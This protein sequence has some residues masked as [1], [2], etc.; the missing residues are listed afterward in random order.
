M[1]INLE[2]SFVEVMDDTVPTLLA[3]HANDSVTTGGSDIH[4]GF[5]F[6]TMLS[7]IGV[8]ALP[9]IALG[10]SF[11]IMG[12]TIVADHEDSTKEPLERSYTAR[13]EV[14]DSFNDGFGGAL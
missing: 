3:G 10:V 13:D 4:G 9:S 6:S 14:G 8:L 12:R 2:K 11:P 1:A 7:V 5:C